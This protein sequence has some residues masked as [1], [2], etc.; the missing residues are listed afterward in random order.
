MIC[1]LL[2]TLSSLRTETMSVSFTALSPVPSTMPSILLVFNQFC[3]WVI[4]T[5]KK[6]NRD[7]PD[8]PVAKTPHSQGRGPRCD[9]HSGNSIPHAVTKTQCRQINIKKKKRKL[10]SAL[11]FSLTIVLKRQGSYPDTVKGALLKIS[12][13]GALSVS[14]FSLPCCTPYC[15]RDPLRNV[16]PRFWSCL[17]QFVVYI[18]PCLSTWWAHSFTPNSLKTK[19]PSCVWQQNPT[20]R[21]IGYLCP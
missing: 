17:F 8:G 19:Y 2:K 9:S 6:K 18:K 15:D 21:T 13:W 3:S 5:Y 11:S 20:G 10:Y 7:F 4:V 12:I 1:P 16:P 14:V